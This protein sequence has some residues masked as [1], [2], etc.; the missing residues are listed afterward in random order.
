MHKS[1]SHTRFAAR[2][3][4]KPC[5]LLELQARVNT[6]A[7]IYITR[8]VERVELSVA[9][10]DVFVADFSARQPWLAGKGGGEPVI[11]AIAV[12]APGRPELLINPEG[13]DYPRFV[14]LLAS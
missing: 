13:Y 9:E 11:H 3:V 5:N 1:A 4:R 14:G 8:I 7:E 6:D 2:F 12:S 10:F